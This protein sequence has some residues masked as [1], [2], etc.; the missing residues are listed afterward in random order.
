MTVNDLLAVLM[1]CEPGADVCVHMPLKK[2]S[3][4]L[5]DIRDIRTRAVDDTI[6]LNL[7]RPSKV[8]ED[9]IWQIIQES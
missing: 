7:D 9:E 3:C 1:K 2:G 4:I 5:A 6:I 8:R